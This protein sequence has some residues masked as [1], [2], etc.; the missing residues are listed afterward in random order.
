M[1]CKGQVGSYRRVL[2]IAVV[3][4]KEIE[5]IVLFRFVMHRLTVDHHAQ[6]F[7]PG[8]NGQRELKASHDFSERLPALAFSNQGQQAQTLKE[9]NFDG[10]RSEEHT[11]ELQ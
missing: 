5:L 6:S 8:G 1:S 7:L 10:V 4:I 2:K 11:S 3:G 9:W